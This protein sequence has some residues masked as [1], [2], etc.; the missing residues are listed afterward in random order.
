MKSILHLLLG[1]LCTSLAIAD[2]PA[3][4]ASGDPNVTITRY[5]GSDLIKH[6]TG[7]TFTRDG[8]LLAVES[9]T[10]FAPDDYNGPKSDRIVWLQDTDGNGT[11]DQRS[12]FFKA[13]LVATMD[14]ATHP[15]TG[16]IYIA[17]RNEVLRVWDRDGDG[18]A[19]GD[20]VERKLVF[21]DTT[22][23]YP[24]NGVSGLCFDDKG[25]LFF[26]IGENYGADYT[27]RGSDG[28]LV[29]HGGEGGN[30]WHATRDGGKLR[31]YATGFWNP[32]GVCTAPGGHVFATDNDPSS[33][34]P[35]RLHEVIDGGDYGYQYRYGRSGQHPFVSWNGNLTGT[36]PMLHGS[37]EAP[38]DVI[39]HRGHLLVASWADH[40]LEQ[41]PLTWNETHFKTERKILVQGGVDFR[42][43]DFFMGS[44]EA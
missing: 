34:P 38:C 18:V 42:P 21:L 2:Q 23:D 24:H 17:T 11:A 43:V 31:R 25:N 40:R 37:G 6:P 33:R 15:E 13:D 22:A 20:S 8:K 14:I 29:S 27:L 19:D 12:I 30:I 28:S 41:Y 36:L 16:A 5:A 7:I 39:F 9:H 44:N 3:V 32:F 10:H 4:P 35:C 1:S 26:G